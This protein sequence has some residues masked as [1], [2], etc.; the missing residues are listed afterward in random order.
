[1]KTLSFEGV[2]AINGYASSNKTTTLDL[3]RLFSCVHQK[4]LD[5]MRRFR[6]DLYP[7]LEQKKTTTNFRDKRIHPK[8]T[9]EDAKIIFNTDVTGTGKKTTASMK[10]KKDS[11]FYKKQLG[12]VQKSFNTFSSV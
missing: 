8:N 6:S 9:A 11:P 10:D 4:E 12:D 2:R 3:L 5:D 7:I 1:M